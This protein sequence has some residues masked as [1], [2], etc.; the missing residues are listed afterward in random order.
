MLVEELNQMGLTCQMPKATFYAWAKCNTKSMN[1]VQKM[2]SVNV[3]ATPGIGF[4]QHGEGYIRFSATCPEDQIEE[5]CKRL[6]K[7]L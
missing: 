3:V 2:L 5:A 7:I 1:F 4:G 6:R